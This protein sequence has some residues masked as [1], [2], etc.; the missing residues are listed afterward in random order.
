[1]KKVL[2]ILIIGLFVLG[3]NAAFS[4]A[5]KGSLYVSATGGPY[6]YLGEGA[7]DHSKFTDRLVMGVEGN[8]FVAN[9]VSLTG[10]LDYSTAGNG[11]TS[12]VFGTRLYPGGGNIFFRHRASIALENRFNSDFLLGAG[13]DFPISDKF[14]AEVNLDYKF[15]S[16]SVGLRIGIALTL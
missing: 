10:G 13:G 3:S 16:R 11:Y 12:A 14:A 1:M 9:G 15:V 8:Y 5:D 4:Q 6:F 7:N 2:T